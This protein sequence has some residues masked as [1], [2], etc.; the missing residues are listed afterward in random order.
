MKTTLY[1][2]VQGGSTIKRM[3]HYDKITNDPVQ[4]YH[5]LF[6]SIREQAYKHLTENQ[7][8]LGFEVLLLHEGNEYVCLDEDY[9]IPPLS[10]LK[11]IP[12]FSV[13]ENYELRI[14][15]SRIK[16]T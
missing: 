10:T 7:K 15:E 6:V 4:S 2:L 13:V 16:K 12:K 1:Y 3:L 8:S 9:D 11:F 14:D 5:N